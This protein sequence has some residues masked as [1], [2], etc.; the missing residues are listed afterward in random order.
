M[1][2][3]D[4][5]DFAWKSLSKSPGFATVAIVTLAL[6]IG[7]NAAIFSI[8]NAVL[9]KPLDLPNP[10]E[11]VFV[12][13]EMQVRDVAYFP[14]SPPDWRDL[15]EAA[16][17]L[18][19]IATYNTF[20]NTLKSPE[21]DAEQV[22]A[23]G[24]TNNFF[25]VA[26]VQPFIGR[27]FNDADAA[28]SLQDVPEGTPFP[29]NTF[30]PAKAALISHG[31]W[32]RRFGG[33]DDI[34]GYVIDVGGNK[35]EIIGVM[36]D[37][38]HFEM[39]PEAGSDPE[40]DLLLPLRIDY[41]NALR[42]NVFLN[43]FGRLKPDVTMEQAQAQL[44][45]F[46][47]RMNEAHEVKKSVGWNSYYRDFHGAITE[48]IRGSVLI[49][50]AAVVFVLLIACAN[51]ANLLLVRASSRS[52]ETAIRA[53]LG[54][55]RSRLL[56]QMLMEA[57]LVALGGALLGLA[58][59]EGGIRFLHALGPDGLPLANQIRLDLNVVL[60][61]V[62]ITV[63]ST[64]LAGMVPALR[65]S[66]LNLIDELRERAGSSR[67]SGG[68]L[69]RDGMVVLEVT[70]SFVLLVGAGLM[71][72][73]FISLQSTDPG[74]NPD[75]VLTFNLNLPNDKYPTPP[76]QFRFVDQ[77]YE[78]ISDMPGV[79][80]AGTIGPLPLTGGGFN[81]RY[82]T[83][84]NSGNL[85][86]YRQADYRAIKGDYFQAMQTE[87]LAG[88]V[89]TRDDELNAPPYIIIDDIMANKNFAN[90]DPVGQKLMVR[91]GPEPTLVEIIGVVRHQDSGQ[92]Q[93]D[94]NE[95]IFMTNELLGFG[96][97][98]SFVVRTQADPDTLAGPIR[99]LV[100]GMDGDVVVQQMQP[101]TVVVEDS[102]A[103]TWFAL[104]LIS[105][106]GVIALILAS[107]GLYSVL[108]YVVRLRQSELGVRMTFGATPSQIF[109]LVVGR[110]LFL[111]AIGGALGV[112]VA[113]SVTRLMQNLLVG[114]SPTDP[115]TFVSI[116]ALFLG[117][118]FLA[119]FIPAQ[120]A[121]RVDPV[122]SLRWE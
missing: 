84:E 69:F 33:R 102:Q 98:G 26:G 11:L 54:G 31:L 47:A 13:G 99:D 39:P 45:N 95:T 113:L 116:A 5:F 15:N 79:D 18:V 3:R 17:L 23:A 87:L 48:E 10:D 19:G 29:Q 83:E 91:F 51:V 109:S 37:D 27:I 44:D 62:L 46:T 73:S 25:E 122:V 82:A 101:M 35:I 14:M 56:R 41:E 60:F 115:L 42:N 80:R 64:V 9:L 6:G 21:G 86:A 38:F 55:N 110:G 88:R 43:A 93:E 24:I 28:Y 1:S 57:G 92:L 118:A 59:A 50:M 63:G 34:L 81:G 108:S 77:L 106:F 94:G 71:V 117:I 32:Q 7:V 20:N 107:V 120:R 104:S 111:A 121:T 65:T 53:A 40:P 12:N 2:F 105:I 30:A 97:F 114:V 74:F 66:R 61:T 49:L 68:R 70:L 22:M 75:N 78:R 76:E 58:L 89:F 52:R 72:R 103:P 96:P 16:D 119:S 90:E 36:P 85:E 67:S 4:D 112:V 100:R 8:V